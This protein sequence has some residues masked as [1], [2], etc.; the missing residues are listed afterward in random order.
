MEQDLI[1]ARGEI[2]PKT[3]CALVNISDSGAAGEPVRGDQTG[4]LGKE[5][6]RF[7]DVAMA[8]LQST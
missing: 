6:A 4:G 3:G 1:G 5:P 7:R 2:L 8:K